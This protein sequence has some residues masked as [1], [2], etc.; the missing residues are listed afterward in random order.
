[1]GEKVMNKREKGFTMTEL[2]LAMSGLSVLLILLV[3]SALAIT[4]IYNK[5][6]I[7]KAANQSG[8]TV[9]EDLQR[10]IRQAQKIQFL[11]NEGVPVALCTGKV[12]YVWSARHKDDTQS[13][14]ARLNGRDAGFVRVSDSG[15]ALCNAAVS[16]GSVTFSTTAPV[17]EMLADN[18]SVRYAGT[19]ANGN[20]TGLSAR[21]I[22]PQVGDTKVM[23]LEFTIGSI[24]G[25]DF[26]DDGTSCQGGK[27]GEF[28]ALNTFT[29]TAYSR[30]AR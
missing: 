4:S 14:I 15:G 24:N 5:G 12:S 1:M 10:S 9:G 23:Q 7:L 27:E 19:Q 26:I 17:K 25:E 29:V 20:I 30:F 28:C 13:K 16:G 22:K 8:R 11:E 21:Y 3:S 2:S 6:L 18:L